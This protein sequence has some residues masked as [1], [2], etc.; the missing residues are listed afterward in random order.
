MRRVS[1]VWWGALLALWALAACGNG[2]APGPVPSG[3]LSPVAGS[4]TPL[5]AR[6]ATPIVQN[7]VPPAEITA[8]ALPTAAAHPLELI[9]PTPGPTPNTPWRPP[10]YPVPWAPNLHDHF[11][12]SRPIPAFYG[13]LPVVDYRYGGVF[14][15]NEV[16]TG[17]DIP[18]QPGTPVLAAG[19]GQV[20]WAGYGLNAGRPGVPGPYGKA[21]MIRHDFGWEGKTLYTVYA[22]LSEVDVKAGW[23]VESGA[24][25]GRMGSTGHT[26]GPHLHFEVRLGEPDGKDGVAFETRNPELWLVPPVGWGLIVG[27][28][29]DSW[30]QPL[31]HNIVYL[32]SE[33]DKDFH[34]RTYTYGRSPLIHADTYY[35]EN[36]VF[37]DLPAGLYKVTVVYYGGFYTQALEVR[38]GQVTFFRFQGTVGFEENAQP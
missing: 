11:V 36:Y 34:W 28:V 19:R 33:Q 38:P 32:A 18:G 27:Q 20:I 8:E 22:H 25:L 10:M 2:H 21:V 31:Y 3:S 6:S 12:F 17:I 13:A 16:H 26:T 30:G 35:R 14:F 9:F 29:L 1:F 37:G 15:E 7:Q 5:P 24:P 4:P 23:W